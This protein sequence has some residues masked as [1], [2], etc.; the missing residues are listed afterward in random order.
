MFFFVKVVGNLFP[1]DAIHSKMSESNINQLELLC[2]DA[3]G[4]I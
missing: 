3:S 4:K 1:I 2:F